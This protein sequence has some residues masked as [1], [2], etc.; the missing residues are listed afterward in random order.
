LIAIGVEPECR[1][2]ARSLSGRGPK[3]EPDV[4]IIAESEIVNLVRRL[5]LIRRSNS[6]ILAIG[7]ELEYRSVARSLSGWGPK[8]EPN[9]LIIAGREVTD[10]LRRL[11]LIRR[12]D[13]S[14]ITIKVELEYRS[15][16][17]SLSG[18]GSKGESNAPIATENKVT[19]FL[20]WRRSYSCSFG[21][22]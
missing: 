6:S 15:V 7:V 18:W 1:S 2:V 10:F 13:S 17:R 12:S 3:G 19:N 21:M 5:K 4:L 22:L 9:A 14:M 8:G 16:A 20:R 11:K